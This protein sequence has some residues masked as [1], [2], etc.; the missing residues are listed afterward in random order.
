MKEKL[1]RGTEVETLPDGENLGDD[2]NYRFRPEIM[3]NV[4]H[5]PKHSPDR[6][7]PPPMPVEHSKDNPDC[8]QYEGEEMGDTW[9]DYKFNEE[10][11]LEEAKRYIG[12]TYSEHYATGDIETSEVIIDSGHGTSAFISAIIKYA[13]R[14]GH[15]DG[16]NRQDLLKIV[17]YAIMTMYVADSHSDNDAYLNMGTIN[18]LKSMEQTQLNDYHKH[19][20]IGI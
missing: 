18:Q 10:N 2:V 5:G 9:I 14:Y 6:F 1:N 11:L 3:Q 7:A 13:R 4:D 17:H 15:K 19:R 8:C 20:K 12:D 16:Y